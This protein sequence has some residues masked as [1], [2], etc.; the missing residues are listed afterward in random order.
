MMLRPREIE[1]SWYGRGRLGLSQRAL[2]RL[3]S[4]FSGLIVWLHRHLYLRG[5]L[6]QVRLPVP[7]LVVGNLIVG[8][9]GKTPVALSLALAAWFTRGLTPSAFRPR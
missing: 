1:A 6:K 5:V 7:V 8:G 9:A 4:W 2:L 3:F